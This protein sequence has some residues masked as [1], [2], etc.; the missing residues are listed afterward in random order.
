MVSI[1]GVVSGV[2]NETVAVNFPQFSDPV[3]FIST[4][5]CGLREQI[6]GALSE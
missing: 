5:V 6:P 4:S 2:E 1:K 3:L